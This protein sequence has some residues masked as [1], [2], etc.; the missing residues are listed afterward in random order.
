[1]TPLTISEELWGNAGGTEVHL[2]T[3]TNA[4]GMRAQILDYGGIIRSLEVPDRAG[5]VE[6]VVLGLSTLDDYVRCNPGPTTSK[7]QGAALYF[8]A[9]IG[10][11]ANRLANGSFHLDGARFDIPVNNGKNALHGGQ[12]GFD[13]KVW[14]PRVVRDLEGDDEVGLRLEYLNPDGEMGFPGALTTVATYILDNRNRLSLYLEATTDAPTVLNLTNHCYWDLSAGHGTGAYGHVLQLNADYYAP[15]NDELLPTGEIRPVAGTPFD[16][17]SPRLIGERIRGA[18]RELVGARG[19]D[20]NW[21]LN[22]TNPRSLLWAAS[23]L[24]PL[25]GRQLTVL[26]TQPGIQFYSGNFLD[27]TIVGIGGRTYRQSDGFALETQH[28]PDSPN[29]PEFPST[30]LRPGQKYTETTIW[31]LSWETSV[32]DAPPSESNNPY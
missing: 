11:Y 21:A 18:E 5:N 27:G 6:N 12:V 20:H 14:R 16:F 22:Q 25:S 30:H 4:S 13:Q 24:D 10:R 1:M 29:H 32:I 28:F 9:L 23:A 31:Q 7:A 3:L 17:R 26:T 2:Y 15:A 8:G 19:Y